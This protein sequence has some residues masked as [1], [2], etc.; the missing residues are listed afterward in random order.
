MFDKGLWPKYQ[1][2]K[3]STLIDISYFINNRGKGHEII[4]YT[5]ENIMK[6]W[7]RQQVQGTI[8]IQTLVSMFCFGLVTLDEGTWT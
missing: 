1:N 6:T 4:L 7:R 8:Q 3:Y 2:F 5:L